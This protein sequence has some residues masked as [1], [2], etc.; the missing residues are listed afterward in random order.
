[1][2]YEEI[3]GI[4]GN[5]P[6]LK[7]EVGIYG[8]LEYMNPTGSHKDRTALYMIKDASKRLRKGDFVIEYTSGNTGISV[9]FISKIM[10]YRSLILVP[11]N[12]S[13]EKINLI[14]VLGG[15]VRII[16]KDENGHDYAR[17]MEMELGGVYLNQTENLANFR[18]HYETT[19]R[20]IFRDISEIQCFVMGVGTG[21]TLYGIGKY[22][23]EKDENIKVIGLIPKNSFLQEQLFG[24]RD[25]DE[26]IFEGFS[27]Y[28]FSGLFKRALDEGIVDEV[29]ITDSKES[30]R[31]MKALLE[32]GVIGGLTSGGHYYHAK[33]LYREC[34]GKIVT[35]IA[36]S[37]LRYPK[38]MERLSSYDSN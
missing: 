7:I 24:K 32:K 31:G 8:K 12:I 15:E 16:K 30:I 37:L 21:G 17:H 33:R 11:E 2:K 19:A 6:L 38:I 29:R 18:A 28:S 22:L 35:I 36:D 26:M 4:I 5:T 9:A 23:K 25:E 10:G 27:Y 1:M 14:K 3:Y 20:E 13:K 34:G